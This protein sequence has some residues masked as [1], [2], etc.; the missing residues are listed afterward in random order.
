LPDLF[1]V[2][3][4]DIPAPNVDPGPVL[5]PSAT[6]D[7][8]LAGPPVTL[9]VDVI[10]INC[11]K[12]ISAMTLLETNAKNRSALTQEPYTSINGCTLQHKSDFF[13]LSM[14]PPG[15]VSTGTVPA[16]VAVQMGFILSVYIDINKN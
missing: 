1:T 12:I 13:C 4:P 2:Q 6:L 3:A 16:T 5:M 8:T 15:T 9:S 14:T 11:G 7:P 10:Q